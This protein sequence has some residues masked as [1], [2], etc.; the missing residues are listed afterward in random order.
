MPRVWGR[1]FALGLA[2]LL[3]APGGCSLNV[4]CPGGSVNATGDCVPSSAVDGDQDR[5]NPCPNGFILN[6]LGLCVQIPGDGDQDPVNPCPDGYTL[7][8]QGVCVPISSDGDAADGEGENES[9]TAACSKDAQC[10]IGTLCHP[11][12]GQG[13]CLAP[14]TTDAYCQGIQSPSYCAVEN[15]CRAGTKPVNCTK[16][17]LCPL[18]DICHDKLRPDGLCAPACKTVG[19]CQSIN[20]ASYCADDGRCVLGSQPSTCTSDGQCTIGTICH[21][22]FQGGVCHEPC[23]YSFD[24]SN[25]V[26]DTTC[27]A[28]QR[29]I[30]KNDGLACKLDDDCEAGTICHAVLTANGRCLPTC[31]TDAHCRELSGQTDVFCNTWGRCRP[32]S[33]TS[34]CQSDPECPINTVCHASAKEGGVCFAACDSSAKCRL[35]GEN[36]ACNA[37][38]RCV[39]SLVT[40][41][42][43]TSE[44]DDTD[45]DSSDGDT[46]E[47]D[48]PD[49]DTAEAE[50]DADADGR[51]PTLHSG[52][53]LTVN[54]NTSKL[55]LKVLRNGAVYVDPSAKSAIYLRDTQT[56]G[57][58][59][60]YEGINKGD[61]LPAVSLI[62]GRYDIIGQNAL[63]QRATLYTNF[64]LEK[65]STL[66][67]GFPQKTL[68]AKLR[69]NG[70]PFPTLAGVHQGQIVLYDKN[71]YRSYTFGRTG[72]GQNDLSMD[73]F[74]GNYDLRF[75]GYLADNDGS[76]QLASLRLNDTVSV[77]KNYIFDLATVLVEGTVKINGATIPDD[78]N[79]RGSL[80]LIDPTRG[81]RFKF[82]DFGAS[83]AVGFTREIIANSYNAAYAPSG[84][85]GS[86]SA[87][88]LPAALIF[89]SEQSAVDIN[90]PL[91]RFSGE[92]F[93][94]DT[95]WPDFTH[96]ARGKL[97]LQSETTRELLSL[98]TLGKSG[99]ARF[100][101]WIVPGSYNLRFEGPL[102]DDEWFVNHTYPSVIHRVVWQSGFS[103][104]GATQQDLHLPIVEVSG[105]ISSNGPPFSGITL[106]GDYVTVRRAGTY[107]DIPLL[108]L[109][110]IPDKTHYTTHLFSGDYDVR[111]LG[112]NVFGSFQNFY[113]YPKVTIGSGPTTLDLPF[114]SRQVQVTVTTDKGRKALGTL[115]AD[116]LFDAVELH[117]IDKTINSRSIWPVHHRATGQRKL[118]RPSFHRLVGQQA[119]VQGSVRVGG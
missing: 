68:T 57:Q 37:D 71:T 49:S 41:D 15:R 113:V 84:E 23:Q 115:I 110:S 104:S 95:P 22:A 77:D 116:G 88:R 79:G 17:E 26:P 118:G 112:S 86:A 33:T 14:C 82:L 59:R 58:F 107:D 90:I 38:S 119:G 18:G 92:A 56:G 94:G 27:S 111:Y 44:A 54:F 24:C 76:A 89:T 16:S 4:V 72:T 117:V 28:T 103:I 8:G 85:D 46:P 73:V 97:L 70:A 39:P 20:F 93:W 109:G 78:P 6:A 74:P 32:T 3:F 100:D 62:N 40:E 47:A 45:G 9:S 53:L 42:G 96:L 67:V 52:E 35:I 83:G 29:C 106:N 60:L 114:V 5:L 51:C 25:V 31:V 13:R 91:V 63:G 101:T 48:L 30:P 80:W 64:V 98:L 19:Y 12:D 75:D 34:G 87:F 10:E 81:D 105:A 36:L 50:A 21:I 102:Q 65:D 55:T 108:H 61:L 69:K 43:D 99:P 11:L 2:L 7:N 1:L 66:E